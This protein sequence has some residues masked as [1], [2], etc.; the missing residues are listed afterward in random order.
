MRYSLNVDQIA[1]RLANKA[2]CDANG[3]KFDADADAF[4]NLDIFGIK[5]NVSRNRNVQVCFDQE[6]ITR[7]QLISYCFFMV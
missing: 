2:V 1:R 4:V 5:E 7:N 6:K 3:A